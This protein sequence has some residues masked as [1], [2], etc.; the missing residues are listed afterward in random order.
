M[1]EASPIGIA[2]FAADV[3]HLPS[4]RWVRAGFIGTAYRL[5]RLAAPRPLL[6]LACAALFYLA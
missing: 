6:V 1:R 2:L 3:S 4:K 5:A